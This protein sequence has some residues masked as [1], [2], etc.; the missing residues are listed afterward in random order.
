MRKKCGKL[1]EGTLV[2]MNPIVT[3]CVRV[4][5]STCMVDTRMRDAARKRKVNSIF[6]ARKWK[7]CRSRVERNNYILIVQR[8]NAVVQ[9]SQEIKKTNWFVSDCSGRSNV[10]VSLINRYLWK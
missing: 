4:S 9:T 7:M 3:V 1:S 2:A 10:N 5:S 6:A 8:R